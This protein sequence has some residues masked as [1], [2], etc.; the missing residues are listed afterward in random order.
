MSGCSRGDAAV[1]G[2]VEPKEEARAHM[3]QHVFDL[4]SKPLEMQPPGAK[5]LFAVAE[6]LSSEW[7]EQRRCQP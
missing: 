3:V 1:T 2:C 6:A 7:P 4:I 5:A